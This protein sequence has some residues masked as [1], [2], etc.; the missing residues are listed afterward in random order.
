MLGSEFSRLGASFD[1]GTGFCTLQAT[2]YKLAIACERFGVPLADHHR[3]ISDAR[4]TALLA[5][6]IGEEFP[7]S[8]AAATIGHIA[9]SLNPRTHRRSGPGNALSG[10]AR[11]VSRAYYPHSD[12]AELAY[13]AALDWVL[14]D[15]Q[16]EDYERLALREVAAELGLSNSACERAHRAY[17]RSIVAAA[18]RDGVTTV[19][20]VEII[21]KVAQSLGISD[22]ATPSITVLPELDGI[23]EGMRVCFTGQARVQGQAIARSVLEEISADIGLQPVPRVTKQGCDILVAANVSSS[24]RKSNLAR[25]YRIPILSV[26]NYVDQLGVVDLLTVDSG[27]Q[28]DS[29]DLSGPEDGGP[30]V[31]PSLGWLIYEL[32]IPRVGVRIAD[33]LASHFLSID[34]LAAAD[35]EDL[36]EVEGIGPNVAGNIR[37]FFTEPANHGLVEILRQSD[38]GITDKWPAFEILPPEVSGKTFVISGALSSLTRRQA[39][40]LVRAAGGKVAGSV[41][42]NT[43][44]LVAGEKPGS[45]LAR[46]RELGVAILS[47]NELRELLSE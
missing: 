39:H 14:D 18:R 27:I 9:Q 21:D 8:L 36:L 32:G 20:E 33:L 34:A 1:V 46:A 13:L 10:L 37:S 15:Y 31:K 11:V 22:V 47:E 42:N 41:S 16:I 43:D 35:V 26:K 5:R 29:T 17:L 30:P 7:N 38:V 4:A 45:K 23:N 40:E 12:E 19:A 28:R 25:Q 24:S 3:A 6:N 44:Y 2:R